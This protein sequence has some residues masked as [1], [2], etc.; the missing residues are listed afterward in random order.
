[1]YSLKIFNNEGKQVDA[2]IVFA[3]HCV[4]TDKKYVALDYQKHVFEP[5][6][7]YCNLDILE[8]EKEENNNLYMTNISEEEWVKVKKA[9][10]TKVFASV[11]DV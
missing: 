8:I 2:K 5:N 6:S 7:S 4:E 11:K 3:F 9:L 1:M 10:Q